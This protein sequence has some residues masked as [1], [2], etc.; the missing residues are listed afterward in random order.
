MTEVQ[1]WANATF[2][3]R[4]EYYVCII[5]TRSREGCSLSGVKMAYMSSN[6]GTRLHGARRLLNSSQFEERLASLER[7]LDGIAAA[8]DQRDLLQ[9]R[10]LEREAG[11]NLDRVQRRRCRV[12]EP[13][14]TEKKAKMRA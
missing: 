5:A 11:P 3:N 2:K 9:I 1:A 4:S 10:R 14:S 7:Q 12:S 8:D 13:C 6:L